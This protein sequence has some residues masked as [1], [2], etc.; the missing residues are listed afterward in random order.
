LPNA[1]LQKLEDLFGHLD[2]LTGN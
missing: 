2:Y 1:V